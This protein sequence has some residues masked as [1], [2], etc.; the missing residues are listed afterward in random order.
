MLICINW[1]IALFFNLLSTVYHCTFALKKVYWFWNP[2]CI[3]FVIKN[4]KTK[5]RICCYTNIVIQLK[6]ILKTFKRLSN[7]AEAKA[8]FFSHFLFSSLFSFW[9]QSNQ[10]TVKVILNV[11]V[12]LLYFSTTYKVRFSVHSSQKI[13][14]FLF[15]SLLYMN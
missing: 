13:P 14:F 1:L 3:V 7:H 11:I 6:I 12:L 15:T 10:G 2:F 4:S 9:P 8:V 5:L